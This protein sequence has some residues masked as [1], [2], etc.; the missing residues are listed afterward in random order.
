MKEPFRK[1]LA[2]ART[3]NN[4]W[5][6]AVLAIGLGMFK[7][8]VPALQAIFNQ[9][10]VGSLTPEIFQP[11]IVAM[12]YVCFGLSFSTLMA[13]FVAPQLREN[14]FGSVSRFGVMFLLCFFGFCW[15]AASIL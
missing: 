5:V 12:V 6:L 2:K 13:A 7:Y 15:V 1:E 11:I 3:V 10:E 14:A 9:Q 4:I 8:S